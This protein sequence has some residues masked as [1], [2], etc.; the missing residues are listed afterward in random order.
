MTRSGGYYCL[1]PH[2]Q[3]SEKWS[4]TLFL[5]TYV[6]EIF[7]IAL[8]CPKIVPVQSYVDSYLLYG[9]TYME[10]FLIIFIKLYSFKDDDVKNLWEFKC[11]YDYFRHSL[12]GGNSFELC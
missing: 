3:I 12:T 2:D 8:F 5:D 6:G 11:L 4:K 7:K 1:V 10:P 9:S